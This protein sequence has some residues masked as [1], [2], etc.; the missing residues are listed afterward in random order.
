MRRAGGFAV[1]RAQARTAKGLPAHPSRHPDAQVRATWK[2]C[3]VYAH[4]KVTTAKPPH[5][6]LVFVLFFFN[7]LH[8]KIANTHI[9]IGSS[10]LKP[11]VD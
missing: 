5:Y 2:L 7:S 10:I 4:D 1:R 11:V 6:F 8:F 9:C 3:R